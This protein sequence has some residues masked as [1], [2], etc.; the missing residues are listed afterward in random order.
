MIPGDD[1]DKVCMMESSQS[2]LRLLQLYIAFT[3]SLLNESQDD[4]SSL[5]KKDS[6][7]FIRFK[8][9][10]LESVCT[11]ISVAFSSL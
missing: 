7:H 11:L 1:N 2:G 4:S 10:A 3:H 6:F 9:K 5:D 8:E